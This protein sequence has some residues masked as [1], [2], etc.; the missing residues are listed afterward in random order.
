LIFLAFW[1]AISEN[2]RDNFFLRLIEIS[3]RCMAFK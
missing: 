2:A 1:F 3:V